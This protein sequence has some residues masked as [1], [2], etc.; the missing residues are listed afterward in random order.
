LVSASEISTHYHS[1]YQRR[2]L[3]W[4]SDTSTAAYEWTEM[5][6]WE[7]FKF[8]VDNFPGIHRAPNYKQVVE[9]MLQSQ[10]LLEA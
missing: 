3:H 7:A 4:F 6:A 8:F 2:D 10:C 5:T 1:K 9:V